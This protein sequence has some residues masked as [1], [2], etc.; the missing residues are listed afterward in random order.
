MCFSSLYKLEKEDD[1]DLDF[2]IKSQDDEMVLATRKF[3][4]MYRKKGGFKDRQLL[5]REQNK[6]ETST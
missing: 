4:N 1:M 5:K 2:E 6:S 3:L